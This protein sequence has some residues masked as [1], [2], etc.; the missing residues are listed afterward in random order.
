V[1]SPLDAVR[2]LSA[3]SVNLLLSRAEFA[4]L[5]LAQAR[6]QIMR[7]FALALAAMMLVLLALVAA[8][9]LF[10]VLAWPR[11]DWVALLLLGLVYTLGAVLVMRRLQREMAETPP[12]LAETLAE[13]RKDRDA[14]VGRDSGAGDPRSNSETRESP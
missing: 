8:S 1:A 2:R 12:L 4:S 5:E 7:W 11:L 6:A 13:V 3:A 9:A 10:V 14:F